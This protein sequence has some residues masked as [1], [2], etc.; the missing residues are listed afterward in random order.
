MSP[1]YEMTVSKRAHP[2]PCRAMEKL[3]ARRNAAPP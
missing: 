1:E 2:V 3:H